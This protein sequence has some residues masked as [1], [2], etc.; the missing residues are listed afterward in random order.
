MS[1]KAPVVVAAPSF[2]PGAIILFGQEVPIV[3]M[4]LSLAGLVLAR[5]IAP[6]PSRPLTRSQALALTML[7]AVV[8]VAG[9]LTLQPGPGTAVAAGVGLGFSGLLTVEFFGSRIAFFLRGM[10][11][12][13]DGR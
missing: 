3:A 13:G 4:G 5:Y 10:F 7:L 12:K 8:D 6:P 2:G 1:I 11:E 9:V